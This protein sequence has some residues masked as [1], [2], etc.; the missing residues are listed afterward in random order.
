MTQIIPL[1][2]AQQ[3]LNGN[4]LLIPRAQIW[5]EKVSRLGIIEGIGSPE[6]VVSAQVTEEYMDTTGTAGNIKYIKRDA[7]IGGDRTMGWILV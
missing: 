1:D 5:T 4:G 3:L 6:G 7:D 2:R